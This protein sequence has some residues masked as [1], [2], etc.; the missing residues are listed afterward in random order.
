MI[1]LCLTLHFRFPV[2]HSS[3][4]SVAQANALEEWRSFIEA[5]GVPCVMMNGKLRTVMWYV[6]SLAAVTP[7]LL[8]QVP[9][10][11]EAVAQYGWTM[12][13]VQ[14]KSLLS[15]IARII[16]LETITA[17]TAKMLA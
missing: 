11:V 15:H 13:S 1:V 16:A 9:I 6:D 12:W 3:G 2:Q 17:G 5:S 8:L 4:W 7:F 10:L 14:A